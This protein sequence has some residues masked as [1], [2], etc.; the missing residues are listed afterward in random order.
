[1]NL[2]LIR[3]RNETEDFLF[4]LNEN[5]EA[6]YKHTQRKVEETLKFKLTQPRATYSFKP[7]I[8]I[9]GSW[10]IGSTSSEVFKSI[11]NKTEKKLINS[12]F[13]R[14]ISMSFQLR[15]QKMNLRRSLVCQI[16]HH[17]L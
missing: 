7:A 4:S 12:I 9:E 15:I 16:L 3:P 10:M 2:D 14:K 8:S 6:L 5:C 17:L 11:F 1:M 13:I